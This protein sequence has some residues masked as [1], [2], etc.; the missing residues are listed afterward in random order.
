MYREATEQVTTD[1]VNA[2]EGL[3]TNDEIVGL[4]RSGYLDQD[5]AVPGHFQNTLISTARPVCWTF[6]RRNATI[7]RDQLASRPGAG[8]VHAFGRTRAR[9]SGPVQGMPMKNKLTNGARIM[10]AA[11]LPAFGAFC[12]RYPRGG[13]RESQMTSY[14]ANE[15]ES[16]H[17]SALHFCPRMSDW[18]T[19]RSSGRRRLPCTICGGVRDRFCCL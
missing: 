7:A 1:V 10:W 15:G 2:W 13:K 19:S 9:E 8:R 11:R 3:H 18:L 6:C 4:F 14:T 16:G 17:R 12:L 5:H